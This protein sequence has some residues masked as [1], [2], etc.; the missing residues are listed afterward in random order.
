MSDR[1]V[2]QFQ[3]LSMQ[4]TFT[5]VTREAG[6]LT[7]GQLKKLTQEAEK[8]LQKAGQPL[9]PTNLLLAMM[10]V[11]T[12][13]VMYVEATNYTYWAYIPN[14]PLVR[15]V[16]WGEVEVQVCT[17]ETNFFP[18]P[19]C[20]GIEQLSQHVQNYNFTNLTI[21]AEGIPLCIGGH[22]FCLSTKTHSHHSCNTWG[23]NYR[24][25]HFAVFT[26]L[27]SS[28]GFNTSRSYLN[29][30]KRIHMSLCPASFFEASLSRLEWEH[31]RDHD[32]RLVMN[33]SNHVIVD[34]SPTH[35]EFLEK[36]SNRSLKWHRINGTLNGQGNE[37]VKW[38]H[39]ALV[40]PPLQ[41]DGHPQLQG[42]I[43]KLW[44]VSG[45]LT[46]WTGN[47]TLNINDPK[48]PFQVHL[49]LINLTLL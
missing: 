15:A 40:P 18:P 14:P 12:C 44:A 30:S 22:S 43:R 19:D 20:G 27:I 31:C 38:Q 11:V 34:W 32:P 23:V 37:T 21:A 35:G 4:R 5:F 24:G 8:T 13:Q 25:Q 39:F 42:D 26:V 2:R 6:P 47:F 33:F 9:N 29:K 48:G 28:R 17:N 46:I 7:W 16:S 36:W 3:E 41:M 10:A 49:I 1:F 45:D